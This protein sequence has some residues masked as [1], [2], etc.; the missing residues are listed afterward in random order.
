MIAYMQKWITT[1]MLSAD[2]EEGQAEANRL[3]RKIYA[4]FT[5]ATG[6]KQHLFSNHSAEKKQGKTSRRKYIMDH[7]YYDENILFG[8]FGITTD[9]MDG[10][11]RERDLITMEEA[12]VVPSGPTKSFE[13][14]TYFGIHADRKQ[15][16]VL[17]NGNM[18]E[19][20]HE[21]IAG[22][23][24]QAIEGEPFRFDVEAYQEKTVR[25]RIKEINKSQVEFRIATYELGLLNKPSFRQIKAK[26]DRRGA[27]YVTMKL[28]FDTRLDDE[29]VDDLLEMSEDKDTKRL[30]LKDAEASTK[31]ADAIDLLKEVMKVKRDV[32]IKH[33]DLDNV[34][35]VWEKFR[36]AML[37]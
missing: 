30:V 24:S 18:P 29:V 10:M 19:N 7:L 23:C 37:Q 9:E 8:S 15:L 33:S 20:V 27:A 25:E 36:E 22:I 11:V 26:A 12:K 28:F 21:L 3:M 17:R 34:D 13:Y 14:Y 31:D 1:Q 5:D 35:F 16:L 4:A 32:K 6:S 2:P